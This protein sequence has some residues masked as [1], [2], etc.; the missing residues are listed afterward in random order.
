M[1]SKSKE[2]QESKEEGGIFEI[3]FILFL[4]INESFGYRAIWSIINRHQKVLGFLQSW[5]WQMSKLFH[6]WDERLPL[7]W[8]NRVQGP[9]KTLQSYCC[10]KACRVRKPLTLVN[11]LGLS[12]DHI[13]GCPCCAAWWLKL[14]DSVASREVLGASV[15]RS[16]LT[17]GEA[18]HS[19]PALG[20]QTLD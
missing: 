14:R 9:F 13:H 20:K 15:P 12:L 16:S 1:D 5:L 7:L 18:G 19:Q 11:R 8:K 10:V 4:R 6:M 17:Y 2:Y 3:L